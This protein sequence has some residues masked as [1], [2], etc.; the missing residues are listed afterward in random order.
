VVLTKHTQYAHSEK[1]FKERHCVLGYPFFPCRW[2]EPRI[3][4][5]EITVGEGANNDGDLAS[6]LVELEVA[7]FGVP[8]GNTSKTT[9]GNTKSSKAAPESVL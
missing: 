3:V 6:F 2:R 1:L 7:Y 9:A 8:R 4:A 5:V